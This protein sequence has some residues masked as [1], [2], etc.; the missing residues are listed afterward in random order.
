MLLKFST[1]E[2]A[3]PTYKTRQADVQLWSKS[4]TQQEHAM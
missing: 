3:A 4:W 2:A 1:T